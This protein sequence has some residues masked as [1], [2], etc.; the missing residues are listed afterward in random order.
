MYA[1]IDIGLDD[2]DFRFFLG[3]LVKWHKEQRAKAVAAGAKQGRGGSVGGGAA[4]FSAAAARSNGSFGGDFP[5][6]AGAPPSPSPP[7]QMELDIFKLMAQ[8]QATPQQVSKNW[9]R[10]FRG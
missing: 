9:G 4:A 8:N 6:P 1:Q 7:S 10:R 2:L 3:A 5:S